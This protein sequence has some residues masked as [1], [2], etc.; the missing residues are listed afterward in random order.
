MVRDL[1]PEE[2]DKS[3]KHGY[4]WKLTG[5]GERQPEWD[6]ARRAWPVPHL[7]F[8]HAVKAFA[9]PH[10]LDGRLQGSCV[11]HL[12]WSFLSATDKQKIQDWQ[13][14]HSP[15]VDMMIE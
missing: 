7:C 5:R 8:Y 4:I 12:G 13:K 1:N 15:V 3:R 10:G 6:A 11:K 14:K 9:C 2:Q